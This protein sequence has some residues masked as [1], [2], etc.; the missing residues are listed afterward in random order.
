M[1]TMF[2]PDNAIFRDRDVLSDSWMPPEIV[3]RDKEISAYYRH[4]KPVI[5][6]S[7]PNHM[8]VY[9]RTGVGKTAT[10]QYMIDQLDISC[11]EHNVEF[12]SVYINCAGSN[13]SYQVAI[14]IVNELVLGRDGDASEMLNNTGYS[15]RGVYQRLWEELNKYTGHPF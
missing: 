5:N 14:D 7:Q 10:T 1:D 4:L 3:G 15:S 6:E 9:G 13:T 8:F 12:D 11:E 2:S